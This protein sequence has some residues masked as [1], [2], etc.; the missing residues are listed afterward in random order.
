MTM[1]EELQDYIKHWTM[2]TGFHPSAIPV[3]QQDSARLWNEWKETCRFKSDPESVPS[4]CGC[5]LYLSDDAK[6]IRGRLIQSK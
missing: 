4:F 1:T 2:A 3:D 5:D 6:E